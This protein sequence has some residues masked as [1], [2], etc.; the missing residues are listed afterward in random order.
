MKIIA[1]EL[2][3]N[4][5]T[6]S[7]A[8]CL[9]ALREPADQLSDIYRAGFL[10]YSGAP[11]PQRIAYMARS[12]RVRLKDWK[13]SSE[14]RRVYRHFPDLT[15]KVIKVEPAVIDFC[16]T[17]FKERHGAQIMP[18]ERLQYILD[19]G[20][21]TEV[22]EYRL[23]NKILGY[24]WLGRD[25][26]A[27]HFYYSFYDLDYV[28]QSLGLW[29]MIDVALLAQEEGQDYLYLGTAYGERGLYKTNFAEIEFWDG[30][31]WNRDRKLLRQLCREDADRILPQID[32]WKETHPLF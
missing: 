10:P 25:K 15:R 17:Y 11:E 8:Y 30:Q 9:Y 16:F 19:S 21:V 7:F 31:N 12:A 24:V 2:G 32:R 29:L 14:N 28:R 6:Y 4:Y 3:H 13:L 22:L 23:K 1:S 27:A 20:W 5:S 18:L 26:Y